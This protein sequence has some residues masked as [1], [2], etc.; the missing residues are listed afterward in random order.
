MAATCAGLR[1]LE[2]ARLAHRCSV[3]ERRRWRAMPVRDI[4][5]LG[6]RG[7]AQSARVC[8]AYLDMCGRSCSMDV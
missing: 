8:C 1:G 6:R 3:H 5:W 2:H 4:G 7:S